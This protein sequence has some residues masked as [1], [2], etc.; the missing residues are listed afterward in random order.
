[1]AVFVSSCEVLMRVMREVQNGFDRG[2][3]VMAGGVGQV[4]GETLHTLEAATD[5]TSSDTTSDEKETSTML[6]QDLS[7]D[8][9]KLVRYRILYT[10]RDHEKIL[11][12]GDKL[13]NYSTTLPD[14]GGLITCEWVDSHPDEARH[15]DKKYIQ[16]YLEVLTRYPKQEKEYDKETVT[17]LREIRDRI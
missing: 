17:V 3:R 15:L 16:T 6:D 5:T 9:L 4:V 1:M 10:K 11:A 13:V 12:H 8:D 14:Y 2:T 7:G